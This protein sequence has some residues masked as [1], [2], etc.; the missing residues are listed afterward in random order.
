VKRKGTIEYW[1]VFDDGGFIKACSTHKTIAEA[2]I[3]AKACTG[4]KHRIVKVE[5][6]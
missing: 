1:A 3:A 6:R 4:G 2:K 5:W